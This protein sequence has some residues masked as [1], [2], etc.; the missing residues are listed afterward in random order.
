MNFLNLADRSFLCDEFAH[1]ELFAR[2]SAR[3]D[4]DS[5][6]SV[7][8]A[9]DQ[10]PVLLMSSAVYDEILE[11][12]GS[13]PPECGGLL[14]GPKNHRAVTHFLLDE[15]GVGTAASFTWDSRGLTKLLKHYIAC[16]VDAKGFVHSHPTGITTLSGGDLVYAARCFETDTSASID[17]LAMPLV[18]E[19]VLYPYVVLRED[20]HRA[21]PAQLVLF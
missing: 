16:G 10:C 8:L 14:L 4:H 20:P 19:G 7:S 3:G 9:L 13:Q 17:M 11:A 5:G 1:P 12:I 6:D 2:T 18:V 21:V 15:A